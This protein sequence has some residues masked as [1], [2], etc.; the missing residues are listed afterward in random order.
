MSKSAGEN[1]NDCKTDFGL[2]V[3]G[4]AVVAEK[5]RVSEKNFRAQAQI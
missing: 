3:H 1:G 4:S 2:H 5:L